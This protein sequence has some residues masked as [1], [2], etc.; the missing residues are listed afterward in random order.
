MS[1]TA[2]V[3]A[4]GTAVVP[5]KKGGQEGGKEGDA[6]VT[7]HKKRPAA[8]RKSYFELQ[9]ENQARYR[10]RRIPRTKVGC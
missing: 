8:V 3:P 7:A 6:A 9:E 10:A 2:I 4:K 1:S 5:A